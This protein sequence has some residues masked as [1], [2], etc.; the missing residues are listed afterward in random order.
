MGAVVVVVLVVVTAGLLVAVD[1]HMMVVVDLVARVVGLAVVDV[2]MGGLWMLLTL[3]VAGAAVVVAATV[4]REGQ[5]M[6]L[7]LVVVVLVV[8]V[9]LAVAVAGLLV[10]AEVPWMMSMLTLAVLGA[11]RVVASASVC[12]V[13]AVLAV[14][15]LLGE[16]AMVTGVTAEKAAAP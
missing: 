6:P 12:E 15:A 2:R 3:V 8:A 16:A 7:T 4:H 9:V 13:L 1:M 11:Q 5:R 14:A 10:Q